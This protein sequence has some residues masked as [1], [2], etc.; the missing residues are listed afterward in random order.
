MVIVLLVMFLLI[1]PSVPYGTIRSSKRLERRVLF[2][3]SLVMVVLV[4][5]LFLVI[6]VDSVIDDDV[7]IVSCVVIYVVRVVTILI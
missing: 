1:D 2:V 3:G 6:V 4:L 7:V 5:M